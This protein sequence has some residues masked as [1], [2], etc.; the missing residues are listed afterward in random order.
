MLLTCLPLYHTFGLNVFVFQALGFPCTQAVMP[1]W[2][3]EQVFNLVPKSVFTPLPVMFGLVFT[4]L[5][6]TQSYAYGVSTL[7]GPPV[8]QSH[9]I[10]NY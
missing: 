3:V 5:A 10:R 7:Y 9:Q 4:Q 2:N 8:G 6:Q 1:Q